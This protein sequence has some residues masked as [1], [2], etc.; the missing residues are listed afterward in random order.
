VLTAN[1]ETVA[2]TVGGL[3]VLIEVVPIANGMIVAVIVGVPL[4]LIEVM[5]VTSGVMV[6]AIVGV[7]LILIEVVLAMG[8]PTSCGTYFWQELKINPK[9][10]N[11]T[12]K[13]VRQKRSN[14]LR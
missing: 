9:T 3:F 10:S 6:V 4:V 2:V 7:L 5:L 13:A 12:N 1:G 11:G 8:V 14:P